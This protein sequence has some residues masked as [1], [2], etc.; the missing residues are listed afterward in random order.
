M[1]LPWLLADFHRL[2]AFSAPEADWWVLQP[3]DVT[4]QKVLR[5]GV[6][7]WGYHILEGPV[8]GFDIV[9]PLTNG[10]TSQM[11]QGELLA[12]LEKWAW[13]KK[14]RPAGNIVQARE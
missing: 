1:D 5:L 3:E 2:L 4:L 7:Q 10:K 12:A 14:Q 13:E 11:L 8:N 6:R 9:L